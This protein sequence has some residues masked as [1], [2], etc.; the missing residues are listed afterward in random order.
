MSSSNNI[1]FLPVNNTQKNSF[2]FKELNKLLNE[3]VSNASKSIIELDEMNEENIQSSILASIEA[4]YNKQ[5]SKKKKEKRGEQALTSYI[6]FCNANRAEVKEKN[7]D[8]DPKDIT[9]TLANMWKNLT[10]EQKKP[11]VDESKREAERIKAA[12][13]NKDSDK[14][15]ETES[16]TEKKVEKKNKSTSNKSTKEDKKKETKSESNKSSKDDKKKETE[17][18]TDEKKEKKSSKSE[19]KVPSIKMDEDEPILDTSAKT[20]KS[21]K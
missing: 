7:P 1:A 11:F 5:E 12:L 8:M 13:Q 3:M 4:V 14:E 9:R 20:K 18:K 2:N 17:T 10:D 21:K 19:V 6:L 15:D 16:E